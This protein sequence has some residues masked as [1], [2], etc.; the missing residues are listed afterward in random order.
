[1]LC[2]LVDRARA[3]ENLVEL[4]IVVALSMRLLDGG[5]EVLWSTAS[6]LS[7]PRG[8]LPIAMVAAVEA[9]LAVIVVVVS[10]IDAPFIIAFVVATWWTSGWGTRVISSR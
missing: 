8:L 3:V 2:A 5:D 10:I 4:C 7:Y 9:T 6:E 1:M